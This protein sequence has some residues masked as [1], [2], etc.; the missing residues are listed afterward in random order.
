[1]IYPNQGLSLFSSPDPGYQMAVA[2]AY[3]DWMK[4]A[5][6]APA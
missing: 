2:K 6:R 4:R 5:V 1:M 3:N